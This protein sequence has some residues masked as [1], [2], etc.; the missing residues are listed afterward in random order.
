[1]MRQVIN[2]QLEFGQVDI[3][4]IKFD[5]KSRDDIPRILRG[6]QHIYVTPVLREAI[7]ELLEKAVSPKVNKN[8]G[9]P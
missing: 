8:N 2:Q 9:R 7:F 6:M 4:K 5:P 3:S 1:M